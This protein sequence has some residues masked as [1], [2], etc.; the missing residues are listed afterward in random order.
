MTSGFNKTMPGLTQVPPQ[1][2]PL[3]IGVYS[4]T[5]PCL[6]PGFA[7]SNFHLF[8]KLK[9]NLWGQNISPVEEVMAAVCQWF[10]EEE[11]DFLKNG[12]QKL[13]EHWQ[14]CIEVRRDLVENRLCTV[15]NKG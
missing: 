11:K 8:P 14:K 7:P 1:L 5:I 15:V 9:E 6:Q 13:L 2:M 3:H 4:A 12:I 10:S